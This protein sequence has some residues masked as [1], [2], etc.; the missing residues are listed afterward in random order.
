M[1]TTSNLGEF[2]SKDCSTMMRS[3]AIWATH[4]LFGRNPACWSLSHG[5]ISPFILSKIIRLKTFPGTDR[6]VI[7]LSWGVLWGINISSLM[8]L[9]QISVKIGYNSS[10]DVSMSWVLLLGCHPVL[11]YCSSGAL[12][13]SYFLPWSACH[14]WWVYSLLLVS[15]MGVQCG[16]FIQQF[17]KIFSLSVQLLLISRDVP[18]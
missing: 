7:L 5:S 11:L 2:H 17:F 15:C 16:R 1:G 3:V 9:S 14:N 18:S 4:D 12:W 6:S 8:A 13:P 10:T